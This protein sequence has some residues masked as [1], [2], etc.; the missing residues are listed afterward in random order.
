MT[1]A[2][3][4]EDEEDPI[5]EGLREKWRR[6]E[7]EGR[8]AGVCGV[9]GNLYS[10]EDLFCRHC[11]ARTRISSGLMGRFAEFLLD[12]AWGFAVTAI[13]LGILFAFLIV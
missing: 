7:E 4:P 10:D 5:P 9:C 2:P 13:I 1:S 11:E 3:Y 6:E 8:R 12:N